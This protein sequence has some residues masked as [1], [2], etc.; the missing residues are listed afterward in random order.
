MTR[1]REVSTLRARAAEPQARAGHRVFG[2]NQS[3][4]NDA[5]FTKENGR[6]SFSGKMGTLPFFIGMHGVMPSTGE[7]LVFGHES[8]D[9]GFTDRPPV[10][11]RTAD[12]RVPMTVALAS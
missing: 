8:F 1:A 4:I 2:M 3:G 12:G 9:T 5:A 10:L 11:V 7:V 6:F